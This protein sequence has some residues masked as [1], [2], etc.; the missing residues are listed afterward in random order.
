MTATT[1]VP[2]T[3][4]EWREHIARPSVPKPDVPSLAELKAMSG[5]EEAQY[6]RTRMVYLGSEHVVGTFDY[7]EIGRKLQIVRFQNLGDRPSARKGLLISGRQRSG[8]STAVLG[9]LK[10]IDRVIREENG[11]ALDDMTVAP[12]VALVAPDQATARKLWERFA[13][14]LGLRIKAR[15]NADQIAE[16]VHQALKTL[17][18]EVVFID[19]VQNLRTTSEAGTAAGS[20]LKAFTERLP[21]TYIWAGVDVVRG[22]GTAGLFSGQMG[23]QMRGRVDP[24]E[25]VG[26]HIGSESD[27]QDW[28][29]LIAMMED[30]LPLA[31]HESGSLADSSWQW[32]H[33]HTGGSVGALWDVLHNAAIRAIVDETER[34]GPADLQERWLSAADRDYARQ[35]VRGTSRTA[36]KPTASKSRRTG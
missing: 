18:T 5:P 22:D 28:K 11:W 19:E 6:N 24:H 20:A 13:L 34:I 32:L 21:I 33:D 2:S 7:Q 17:H 10:R 36:N 3:L 30:L 16:R 1:A 35:R 15:E 27:R 9:H 8:K 29:D 26:H 14:Y 25:M 12:T 23:Q 31:A 4:D